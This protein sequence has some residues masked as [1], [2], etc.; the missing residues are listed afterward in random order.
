MPISTK[1]YTSY[2]TT[3]GV[4]HIKL[5]DEKYSSRDA[6]ITNIGLV[7]E[8]SSEVNF[9]CE[10]EDEAYYDDT[11]YVQSIQKAVGDILA[12]AIT[13]QE[14]EMK[15]ALDNDA[16]VYFTKIFREY[17]LHMKTPMTSSQVMKVNRLYP[18]PILDENESVLPDEGS[19]MQAYIDKMKSTG[20]YSVFDLADN[21][22][23]YNMTKKEDKD[24]FISLLKE[25]GKEYVF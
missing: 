13:L 19:D 11:E 25:R 15:K 2:M 4:V 16:D 17:Q 3:D 24:A 20:E 22:K 23:E 1:W 18:C 10:F 6:K 5:N 8:G 14:A 21:N 7:K 12:N 9:D